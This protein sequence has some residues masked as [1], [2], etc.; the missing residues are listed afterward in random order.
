MNNQA[1]CAFSS[2]GRTSVFAP[3][4]TEGKAVISLHAQGIQVHIKLVYEFT[5]LLS[6]ISFSFL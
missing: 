2:Q 1:T 6:L 4:A 5:S 3:L